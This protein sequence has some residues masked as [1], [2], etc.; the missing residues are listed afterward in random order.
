VAGSLW[1]A[2]AVGLR[3][4]I[5]YDM[6]GTSTDVCLVEAGRPTTITESVFA[7]YPVKGPQVAIN[8]VGAGGGSLAWL[9]GGILQVGPRS[10]GADPGP[11]CYG[12]GGVEP[13]VTDANLV[14][15]RIGT[16]RRLGD[17][18]QLDA[19]RARDAVAT[20]GA[21]LGI[22][23]V[24]RMAEGILAIAVARMANAI[25]EITIEQGHDP[26]AF[27]LVAFGGAGPMHA[28][29]VAQELAV[30]DLLVPI[31]PGH[32]SALGLLA[33]D[34]RQELVRTHLRRLSALDP[35]GLEAIL[36]AHEAA[37]SE[38][39]TGDR[40]PP[41]AIRFAHRLEMRYARQA[42]EVA[43]D[44]PPGPVHVEGLRKAFLDTYEQRY[45][46]ADPEA[47]IELVNVRTTVIGITPKPVLPRRP[48]GGGRV[49]EAG[50][51]RRPVVMGGAP[52]DCPVYDRDRLPGGA[53]FDGPAIVEEAGATTVILPGWRVV[54][55]EW[56]N[57][58]LTAG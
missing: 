27:T 16:T 39:L 41:E 28:C 18:I 1:V 23:D 29:E 33:S 52:L 2:E 55:D 7:G 14:L 25:R 54:V 35:A 53:R 51:A 43:V 56:G 3:N 21:R 17:V 40:F 48:A 15:G 57:L 37:G 49:G 26:A 13:T 58:R 12:R 46:H 47:E 5:T 42:F 38:A 31:F 45:G 50:A 44:L 32:L 19:G 8:T 6:G 20:L 34:Q 9:D 10:A 30:R 11:A 24:T 4:L 36:R 22:A